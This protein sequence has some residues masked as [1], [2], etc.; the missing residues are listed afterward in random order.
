MAEQGERRTPT[1]GTADEEAAVGHRRPPRRDQP[2]L[3]DGEGGQALRLCRAC[4]RRR[5]EGSR[6]IRVRQGPKEVPEAIRK[7]TEEAKRTR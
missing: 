3:E 2:R 1:A 5:S 6:R 7:A 4:R